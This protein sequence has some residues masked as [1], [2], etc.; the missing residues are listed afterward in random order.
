MM[1]AR[2]G[3]WTGA[4]SGRCHAKFPMI[5]RLSAMQAIQKPKAAFATAGSVSRLSAAPIGRP[6]V[7]SV[8]T[9]MP[10]ESASQVFASPVVTKA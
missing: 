2:A 6:A 9:R 7:N 10:A 4:A 3:D 8:I 5:A 1:E